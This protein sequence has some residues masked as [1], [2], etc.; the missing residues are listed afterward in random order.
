MGTL[1]ETELETE[2][3]DAT[4]NRDELTQ[5]KIIISMNLCQQRIARISRWEELNAVATGSLTYTGNKTTDKFFTLPSGIRDI[6][7]FILL[8]TADEVASKLIRRS[9]AWWDKNISATQYFDTGMP[10]VYLWFEKTKVEFWRVIDKVYDYQIRYCKWPTAF[11]A[12]SPSA[13]SDMDEKDDMIVSLTVSYIFSKLRMLEDAG[14]WFTIFSSQLKDASIEEAE[15]PD[16]DI[17]A[18]MNSIDKSDYWSDPFKQVA[19]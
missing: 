4:G 1:T 3:K 9:M 12:S 8:D 7:S 2:I 6:F 5:S 17:G 10:E 16:M 13:V 18:F 19:S 15:K 14:R 11:S